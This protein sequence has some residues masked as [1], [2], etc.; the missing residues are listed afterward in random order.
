LKKIGLTLGIDQTGAI[1]SNGKPKSLPV[2]YISGSEI[3]LDYLESLSTIHLSVLLGS[4]HRVHL[5]L[6]LD[7]VLGLPRTLPL[8]LRTAIQSTLNVPGY[9]RDPARQFFAE[10]AKNT[11]PTRRIEILA[12]AN[13]V[14]RDKPFQKNIQTGTFRFWKDLAKDPDWFYF[15]DVEKPIPNRTPLYEAYP[16]YSWRKL[17]GTPKRD[18]LHLDQW[19]QKAKMPYQLPKDWKRRISKDPN[20]ADALVIALHLHQSTAQDLKRKPD[21]EG[22]I[23]GFPK[24]STHELQ[25]ISI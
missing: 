5:R 17:L 14:F 12:Q 21:R 20:L 22:W 15:P 25:R 18:P 19:M 24:P 6:A 11:I 9:G 16:S 3:H 13:S 4:L 8:S 23:L 10:I 2:S 7:C 1:R